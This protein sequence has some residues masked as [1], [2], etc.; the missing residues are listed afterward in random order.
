[1]AHD[2]FN[3]RYFGRK[4][5]WHNLGKVFEPGQEPDLIDAFKIGRL[6][7]EFGV[8]PV[9]MYPSNDFF[10][11]NFPGYTFDGNYTEWPERKVIVRYPTPDDPQIVPMDIVSDDYSIIQNMEIAAMFND[12]S[13]RWTVETV[14]A[15]GKGQTIFATLN[16]GEVEIGGELIKRF[17]IINDNKTGLKQ[18]NIFYAPFEV[19]CSNTLRFAL[20]QSSLTVNVKHRKGNKEKIQEI[21]NIAEALDVK[22]KAMDGLFGDMVKVRFSLNEFD[23]LVKNVL[24]PE[25]IKPLEVTDEYL[26]L[27]AKA[28]EEQRVVIELFQ[29]YGDTR[30]GLAENLFGAVSVVVDHEDFKPGRGNSKYEQTI[31]KGARLEKKT[32]AFQY[33]VSKL[34]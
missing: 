8:W 12:L 29:E 26:K 31:F 11:K 4:P 32:Q 23:E 19:V 10:E 17:F 22:A 9:Q 7:Y 5:A 30:P 20:E 33:L 27:L 34:N 13:K 24:Y 21:A 28:Q 14:G 6:D 2:L 1:M 18:T 15:L 25:P 16:C 3:F